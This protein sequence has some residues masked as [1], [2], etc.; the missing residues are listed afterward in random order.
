MKITIEDIAREAKVSKMTVSRVL[1]GKNYVAKETVEKVKNVIR[2]LDYQP[3][4]IARSLSQKKTMILGVVIPRADKIF[5]DDYIA[6]VLSGITSV[7][8]KNDYK[9]LMI[10]Y[11]KFQNETMD[12]LSIAKSKLID[13]MILLK[14]KKSDYHINVLAESGFPFILVNQKRNSNGINYVDSENIAGAKKAVQYLYNK[15][16]RKIAFVV[17]NT[18]ETNANDRLNGYKKTLK[19]LN[20]PFRKEFIIYGKFEK[21]IAYKETDKLLKLKDPPTAIFCSDDYMAIGVI[22]KIK[23]SGL[24]VPQ[25][26]AII[27]FDN[28]EIGKYMKPALTTIKQPMYEIGKLTTS[29]L[30]DLISGKVKTPVKKLLKTEIVVRES[31]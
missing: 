15:G 18:D 29:I 4:L 28:I 22:N 8:L 11:N 1:N 2:K 26:I 10:A 9:I 23:E 16:H 21:E 14:S 6:Q 25:D 7:A 30:L 20:L 3:N 17:G 19:E 13:G 27:G 12:Y 5:L 24:K 31:A